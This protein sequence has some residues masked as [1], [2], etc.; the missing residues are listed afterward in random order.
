[1]GSIPG[2]VHV[3]DMH[4][5]TSGLTVVLLSGVHGNEPAGLEAAVQVTERIRACQFGFEG[6][7]Y[8][9]V[10]NPMAVS[11]GQ[12][13][14]DEDLNRI[15]TAETIARARA[16]PRNVEEQQMRSLLDLLDHIEATSEKVVFVD[17][18]STSAPG[19]PFGATTV[20]DV[21]GL[22]LMAIP[23]PMILGL[24]TFIRGALLD[25][26]RQ[27]G[28]P[29]VVF[30]GG[31]HD[32]PETVANLRCCVWSVVPTARRAIDEIEDDLYDVIRRG[33]G[34]PRWLEVFD[35]H[36][37]QPGDEFKMAPGFEN[38]WPVRRGDLLARDR[39]G[40]IHAQTDGFLLM[41][42][43]QGQ[44]AEGFLLAKPCADPRDDPL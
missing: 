6:S 18:H 16:Q 20:G 19:T 39:D 23:V 5:G 21:R 3:L 22:S 32:A 13:Y 27:R 44:G 33:E 17:L 40:E 11:K 14:I 38:F 30:E 36:R 31:Q 37:I 1:M 28:H 35:A 9:V 41:P 2:G 24:E 7:I 8:A 26:V 15:W 10:A 29:A 4:E 34:P 42:L 12:R 25:H 43:Y